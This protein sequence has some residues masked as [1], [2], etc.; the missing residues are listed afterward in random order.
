MIKRRTPI[1]NLRRASD[2]REVGLCVIITLNLRLEMVFR[3]GLE[4]SSAGSYPAALSI[5]LSEL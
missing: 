3:E 2:D 1:E 5:E 4:P